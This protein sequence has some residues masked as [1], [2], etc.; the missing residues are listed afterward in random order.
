MSSGTELTGV[1]FGQ[2]VHTILIL[3]I[4]SSGVVWRT[5]FTTVTPERKN[6]LVKENIPRDSTNIP[7]EQLQRVNQNFFR[8]FEECLR[9]EGQHF[10]YFLW[11]VNCNYFIPNVIGQQ[12]Y[13]VIGKIRMRPAA[14]GAPVAMNRSTNVKAS[15]YIVTCGLKARIVEPEEKAVAME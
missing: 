1:V 8:L 6:Y 2:H 3:A 9:E 12:A 11:A 7:A 15:L 4:F 10:Q 5:K 13:W 14:G